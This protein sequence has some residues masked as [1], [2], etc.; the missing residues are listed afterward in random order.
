MLVDYCHVKPN[1]SAQSS[2]PSNIALCSSLDYWK[3]IFHVLLC[4]NIS[5][6]D[7]YLMVAC[8][9]L[10]NI[11]NI[12]LFLPSVYI[13]NSICLK[14]FLLVNPI[15]LLITHIFFSKSFFVVFLKPVLWLLSFNLNI[16]F[17]L[18]YDLSSIFCNF[19]CFFDSI[20]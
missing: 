14:Y 9:Y 3:V 8:M 1:L 19:Q 12:C 7:V 20:Q 16:F 18:F 11:L 15:F 5:L 2:D 4:P 17:L 6:S 10:T 13:C